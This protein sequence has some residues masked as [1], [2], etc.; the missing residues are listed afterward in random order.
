M[1]VGKQPLT[2]SYELVTREDEPCSES[3]PII[4]SCEEAETLIRAKNSWRTRFSGW[5]GG[6]VASITVSVLVLLLNVTLAIAA[7]TRWQPVGNI[8]TAFTGDCTTVTRWTTAA[9]LGINLLSSLLLGAS[10]YCMQRLVAP[11]RKEVDK[12]HAQRK[13]LDIGIPS[14]RNLTSISKRRL[15]LWILLALSSIPLHF[16]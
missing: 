15:I 5:R 11:T 1:K 9:H 12:A 14:T 7:A 16:V 4:V 6:V 13:W 10:N 8:A 3:H 2:D